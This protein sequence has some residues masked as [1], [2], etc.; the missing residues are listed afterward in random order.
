MLVRAGHYKLHS[1]PQGWKN[2]SK[3]KTSVPVSNRNARYRLSIIAALQT[4]QNL[5]LSHPQ[6]QWQRAQ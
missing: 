5:A 6:W 4:V 2:R 1:K 3:I